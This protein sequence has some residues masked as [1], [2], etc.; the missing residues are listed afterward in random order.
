MSQLLHIEGLGHQFGEIVALEAVDLSLAEQSCLAIVGPNGAGKSTL[1]NCISGL[2]RPLRGTLSFRGQSLIGKSIDQIARL[3][4][5]RTFQQPKLF[6][7][8][9]VLQHLQLAQAPY[10]P[11]R[12]TLPLLNQ[13]LEDCGLSGLVNQKAPNLSFGQQKTLAIAR[14]IA[15]QAKLILMD[16]PAAGLSEIEKIDFVN[17]IQTLRSKYQFSILLVEHQLTVVEA[18]ADEVLLLDRGKSLIQANWEEVKRST[19]WQKYKS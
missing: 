17:L 3:G 18:L 4:I 14:C 2:Y 7:S 9:S 5:A 16:E 10:G 15:S 8:L 11:L 12:G 13:I 19:Q 1:F 6:A